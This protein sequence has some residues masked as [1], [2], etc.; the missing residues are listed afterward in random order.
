MLPEF[1]YELL[2]SAAAGGVA[3]D[4]ILVGLLGAVEA[5]AIVVYWQTQLEVQRSGFPMYV[6]DA[7]LPTFTRDRKAPPTR[8]GTP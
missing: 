2:L 5:V 7:I 8:T 6:A 3:L 1:I 4:L